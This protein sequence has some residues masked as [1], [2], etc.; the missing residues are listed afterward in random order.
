MEIVNAYESC[1]NYGYKAMKLNMQNINKNKRNKTKNIAIISLSILFVLG[2]TFAVYAF[3]HRNDDE[4]KRDASGTSIERTPQ[5][6]ALEENLENNPSDKTDSSQTD[7]PQA[8]SVEEG[9]N[10]QK[11]NVVLTNVGE[12]NGTVSASGFVS[13]AVEVDGKCTYVF[14][15]GQEVYKKESTT[16]TNANSTTCKTVNFPSSELSSGTWKVDIE[17]SSAA[18]AGKSNT[19]EVTV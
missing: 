12:T 5:D 4:I 17:Y 2:A 9:T 11:V 1:Y 8:P 15:K 13:N 10:L 7:T 16:L 14:T 3:I 19:L 18:S 6:K